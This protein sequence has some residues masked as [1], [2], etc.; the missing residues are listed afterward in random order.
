MRL[1]R[2]FGLALLLGLLN[3]C[4]TP[5]PVVK[6][7]PPAEFSTAVRFL[8]DSLATQIK[9]GQATAGLPGRSGQTSV[10]IDPFIDGDTGDV[11]QASVSIEGIFGQVMT[12]PPTSFGV[13]RLSPSGLSAAN[14]IVIGSMVYEPYGAGPGKTYHLYASVIDLKNARLIAN[15]DA[16]ISNRKIDNTPVDIYKNSPMYIQDAP[17]QLKLV[18]SQNRDSGAGVQSYLATLNS[19]A[20]SQEASAAF[21]AKNYLEAA[22]QYNRAI[23]LP[24]GRNMRNFSGL[25]QSYYKSNQRDLAAKAFYELFSSAVSSGKISI[26][27]LFSVD[28]VKFTSDPDINDQYGIWLD[29]ASQYFSNTGKCLTIVGHSSHTGDEDYN[30]KLSLRRA[31][32][33]EHQMIKRA[34]VLAKQIQSNGRGFAENIV[35]SG[36]DDAQDAVDRRVA[37]QVRP[38][39]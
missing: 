14:Y 3:A 23:S 27:F 38:C 26:K 35:G 18:L 24:N 17:T 36:T 12:P 7:T 28:S 5:L 16:W 13:A 25:Y 39:G 9:N 8:A 30:R 4:A 6:S 1:D 2:I 34:P 10:L 19:F 37:F 29:Q 20:T 11:N 15:A 22:T 32:E 33:I 21:A 31:Q